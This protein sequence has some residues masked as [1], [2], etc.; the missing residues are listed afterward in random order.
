MI[1]LKK[2]K[3]SGAFLYIPRAFIHLRECG[4]R[5]GLTRGQSRVLNQTSIPTSMR[6]TVINPNR[7]REVQRNFAWPRGGLLYGRLSADVPFWNESVLQASWII[8][9]AMHTYRYISPTVNH[10]IQKYRRKFLSPGD[11]TWEKKKK[12]VTETRHQRC[13]RVRVPR[14]ALLDSREDTEKDIFLDPSDCEIMKFST[15]WTTIIL[16]SPRKFD[17]SI[18]P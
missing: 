10:T 4:G 11:D 17:F 9:P 13:S 7:G 16:L 1:Y 18:L 2:K 3:T 5:A 8:R 15:V 14:A 6:A 12:W